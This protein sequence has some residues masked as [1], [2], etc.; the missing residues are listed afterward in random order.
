[1]IKRYNDE[2]I[3]SVFSDL[4]KFLIQTKIEKHVAIYTSP[5]SIKNKISQSFD[6]INYKILLES[7]KKNEIKTKHE[8]TALINSILEQLPENLHSYI[9]RGITSSDILDTT[10]NVQIVEAHFVLIQ[11][12]DK[13]LDALLEKANKNKYQKII[14]RSHGMFG[15]VTTL[16]LSF[17]N[18]YA[19]WTRNKSRL[20]LAIKDLKTCKMSGAMGNYVHVDLGLEEYIAEKLNFNIEP[21]SSQ[22]I[23]RDKYANYINCISLLGASLERISTYIRLLS[24]N[25]VDE[26]NESFSKN[27]TGSSA[28]PHKKNPILSEN[29]TGLSRLLKM[30]NQAT[31][32]NVSLWYE[33]DMS[34]SSVE[35]VIIPDA[36]NISVFAVSRMTKI[37]KNLHINNDSLS[38]NINK[39]DL[40]LSQTL[41]VSLMKKGFSR[42]YAYKEVQ[43]MCFNGES[44][45][46]QLYKKNYF[47]EDE[48]EEIFNQEKFIKK[49]DQIFKRFEIV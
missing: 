23:C 2:R 29:I 22:V 10:L 31:L 30:Y 21:I 44:I 4:S 9:H 7:I 38:Y 37:I 14:G 28:M 39:S 1:M 35:R 8:T 11:E 16:G 26:V 49:V 48:I 40:Y 25:G 41:L 18:F 3:N 15:E 36:F 6:K 42:Q 47:T 24:Q 12:I 5:K 27:Q 43:E 33:R 19:E 45:K 17:L 34:H 20:E 46:Y 32:D 13:L